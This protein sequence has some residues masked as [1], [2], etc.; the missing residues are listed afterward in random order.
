[1]SNVESLWRQQSGNSGHVECALWFSDVVMR[2]TTMG[3]KDGACKAKVGDLGRM[4]YILQE[5][6]DYTFT[7]Q[8]CR[9][10]ILRPDV[11][12]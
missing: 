1:M 4:F 11:V 9:G 6:N 2:N 8:G 3:G 12:F 7:L 5:V 10:S